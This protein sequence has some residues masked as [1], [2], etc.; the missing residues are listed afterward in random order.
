MSGGMHR[1]QRLISDE[2]DLLIGEGKIRFEA[3]QFGIRL[4]KSEGRSERRGDFPHR[5][6]VI[7]MAVRGQNGRDFEPIDGGEDSV[8]LIGGVDDHSIVTIRHHIHIVFEWADDQSLDPE[9]AVREESFHASTVGAV[10]LLTPDPISQ[11]P[12]PWRVMSSATAIVFSISLLALFIGLV[13]VMLWRNS[14]IR[15]VPTDAVYV[16]EDATGFVAARLDPAL[17]LTRRDVRRILEWEIYFLQMQARQAHRHGGGDIV[18][19]GSDQA[20]EYIQ[21]QAAA[22]QQAEYRAEQ[23]RGVLAEEVAYLQ[24]IGAVGEVVT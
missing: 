24:S 3:G 18:A 20:V 16:I 19:G 22:K 9:V 7:E 10:E 14:Q 1:D 2:D 12:V 23:I 21:T 5:A 6:D 13:A 15:H 4:V 8:C 11:R 17:S